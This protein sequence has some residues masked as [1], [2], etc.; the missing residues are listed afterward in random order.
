MVTIDNL[1][2]R[3]PTNH[4]EYDNILRDL[5]VVEKSRRK[6]WLTK[7]LVFTEEYKS[8]YTI[9]SNDNTICIPV[10]MLSYV[11][12]YI[13]TDIIDNRLRTGLSN[14]DSI[15]PRVSEYRE[16]LEGITL[17]DVQIMAIRKALYTKRCLIQISTG[18]G[19]TEI[20]CALTKILS[21]CNN[22]IIPT[23]LVI[24]PTN[25]LVQDISARFEKYDIPVSIYGNSRHILKNHVNVCH[26]KSLGN[27]LAKDPELLNSIQVLFGD[28]THHLS[29]P[30]FRTP[31]YYM[32]SLE[33]S[34]GLSASVI[35][36]SHVS[37]KEITEYSYGEALVIGAT[38]PL[39][40]NVKTSNM[41][42]AGSLATPVL[43]VLDN[44]ADESLHGH[45][46]N[47]WHAVSLYHLESESRNWL[48]V[49]AAKMFY[50]YNRKT[51][52]LVKTI[53]WAHELL[54]LFDKVGMRDVVRASFGG[55]NYQEYNG[56]DFVQDTSGVYEKFNSG[57]Y[58][59][60]I[61][62]SHIY[63]GADIPNLD[64]VILAYGG[65]N[66]RLQIQGIGRALRTTK[67]GKYAWIIDFNDTADPVLN[68]QYS[69]R[70]YRYRKLTGITNDRIYEGISVDS[71]EGIFVQKEGITGDEYDQP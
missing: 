3:V 39:V 69:A 52:I 56:Y 8:L 33:Y 30:S 42:D 32:S 50:K 34:I 19:K 55:G 43:A 63:E 1:W 22:G 53:R 64:T 60:L 28:E 23:V 37:N 68:R 41:V 21:E 29:A 13:G 38:G 12:K 15:I 14:T 17:R 59:V 25:R 9:D 47:D 18:G 16:I 70:M 44:S 11:T 27:D 46:V 7:E 26:P 24:E 48:V 51:L 49:E 54:K 31:T 65:K 45:A 35:D 66:E 58:S 67:T 57:E 20:M 40:M 62:T 61:G 36:Q 6:D 10:G 4:S 5:R 2:I 71:L